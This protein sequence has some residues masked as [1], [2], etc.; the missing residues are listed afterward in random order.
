MGHPIAGIQPGTQPLR[1]VSYIGWQ[2]LRILLEKQ[3]F[4]S[5]LAQPLDCDM[6]NNQFIDQTLCR[7]TGVHYLYPNNV[8]QLSSMY[9]LHRV[10]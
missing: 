10:E 5:H 2:A 9:S 7:S 1:P 6:P 3:V 4:E 8:R